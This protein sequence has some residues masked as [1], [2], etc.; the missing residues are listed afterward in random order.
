MKK[1]LIIGGAGFVGKYL[2]EYLTGQCGYKVCST[3]MK[4]EEIPGAEYEVV[5]MNLL[6]KEEVEQ[7]INDQAPDYIF[8][9]AAQSSVAVSWSNPQLTV[10]VNIKGTLVLLDVLKEMEYKGRVL[11][12]GSGEEYG[13]IRPDEVPI[14]EDTVLRPGNIYAA[15]KSCQNMLAGIYAKA[16]DL[17][18]IMVRAFNHVGPRQSPQFVVSDFCKQVVEAEKGLR[19]PVIHVGNLKAERDFTDVRDVVAAYECLVR[20]GESGETYNVGSGTAYRIEEIL[21]KIIEL[22]GQKIEVQVEKERLRPID[23]PIIAADITKITEH[24][25]WRP[26]ISLEQTLRDTLDYWRGEAE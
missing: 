14:V 17:K 4:N 26:A 3:K 2:A 22:S 5:D 25:D 10:D 8:H 9:L 13:R 21:E 7:V 15:T 16:Y 6:V 20:Q 11:L 1:A 24:T 18:L 12:I 23:V 19:K